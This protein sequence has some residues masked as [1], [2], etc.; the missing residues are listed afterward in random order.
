MQSPY[1][2]QRET[3]KQ[4][5]F[6]VGRYDD[7][8]GRTL[9]SRA[10]TSDEYM[11][12][13]QVTMQRHPHPHL[14]HPGMRPYM[15]TGVTSATPS[16]PTFLH[17]PQGVALHPHMLSVNS[18]S[19]HMQPP[20]VSSSASMLTASSHHGAPACQ[21]PPLLRV[22]PAEKVE[23][24]QQQ[25]SHQQLHKY[26]HPPTRG[27]MCASCSTYLSHERETGVSRLSPSRV[28]GHIPHHSPHPPYV[29]KAPP[30]TSSSISPRYMQMVG[31]GESR[32]AVRDVNK[33][34][35]PAHQQHPYSNSTSMYPV[36]QQY[37]CETGKVHPALQ[38][39]YGMQGNV[40]M[41]SY[42]EGK[43]A[44]NVRH[45][46]EMH[47]PKVQDRPEQHIIRALGHPIHDKSVCGMPVHSSGDALVRG[48]SSRYTHA[49]GDPVVGES[50]ALY[51]PDVSGKHLIAVHQSPRVETK[52]Q[53]SEG[54][55]LDLT[56]KREGSLNQLEDD[57]PLDLSKKLPSAPVHYQLERRQSAGA[58]QLS[59]SD[60]R[61]YVDPRASNRVV[62]MHTAGDRVKELSEDGKM[63]LGNQHLHNLETS[64][65]TYIQKCKQGVPPGTVPSSHNHQ[66]PHSAIP[67][68]P[69]HITSNTVAV[70]PSNSAMPLHS[71]S[72]P[73]QH[74]RSPHP[75]QHSHLQ[76]TPN[77]QL[78]GYGLNM[79]SSPHRSPFSGDSLL[80]P[81]GIRRPQLHPIPAPN[82]A[83]TL[84]TTNPSCRASPFQSRSCTNPFPL[85]VVSTSPHSQMSTDQQ[86][87]AP[88]GLPRVSP[89]TESCSPQS[90]SREG[91]GSGGGVANPSN[92]ESNHPSA[93]RSVSPPGSDRRNSWDDRRRGSVSKHEPIQNIIGNH[94]PA[95]ILY[96]ICRLCRQTYGSPYGFRKHFRNQHGFEPKA[97]HTI[98]QT[99]SAT[100]NARQL[101]SGSMSQDVD[102]HFEDSVQMY[103]PNALSAQSLNHSQYAVMP[104][105]HA[106]VGRGLPDDSPRS[107]SSGSPFDSHDS[108]QHSSNIMRGSSPHQKIRRAYSRSSI[109]NKTKTPVGA[110]SGS[111]DREDTKCLECPECGQTFQLN[112]FGSYKRHCRQHGQARGVG[113]SNTGGV[114]LY[115]CAECQ[116]TFPEPHLLQE[117]KIRHGTHSI[118]ASCHLCHLLFSSI[119]QVEEHLQTS[120]GQHATNKF[121]PCPPVIPSSLSSSSKLIAAD[122][123]SNLASSSASTVVCSPNSVTSTT[124]VSVSS[125][126]TSST[127][128]TYSSA[129]GFSQKV[130]TPPN[131]EVQRLP[132]D[133][134]V[135][136][137]SPDSSSDNK[138]I[139]ET[140][141]IS[142]S[143][144]FK[145]DRRKSEDESSNL[146]PKL[147]FTQDSPKG[148]NELEGKLHKSGD[149][150]KDSGY[151]E[152]CPS[153]ESRSFSTESSLAS[154][155]D[156]DDG[157]EFLYKH[158]KFGAHRKRGSSNDVPEPDAKHSRQEIVHCNTSVTG[159]VCSSSQPE[160][161]EYNSGSNLDSEAVSSVA[162]KQNKKLDIM[163]KSPKPVGALGSDKSGAFATKNLPNKTEA[164]HQ[165]P[166]VWDRVTRSQAGKNARS[167]D[168]S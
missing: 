82:L 58:R 140:V 34:D 43:A 13:M 10:M 4:D 15:G 22:G 97:E 152:R 37:V 49:P 3:V 124:S 38:A 127:R 153:N 29:S 72:H 106:D 130:T 105:S 162:E 52:P 135:T 76:A 137:A 64:L 32:L 114:G 62:G 53:P 156:A 155:M 81:V 93:S 56:L 132:A 164:R 117:H 51:P 21:P 71:S 128:L 73:H 79:N 116:S 168:V 100:K 142:S 129:T 161:R 125:D 96:L 77:Q 27:C 25:L 154:P 99:I 133:H 57:R 101:T 160:T 47:P 36:T 123:S 1:C 35:N 18:S 143:T 139:P 112:D 87:E 28:D 41:S 5:Q 119:A 90:V 19:I 14:P 134:I 103:P 54:P 12:S 136:S 17:G 9:G 89:T 2:D 146:S 85:S 144:Q 44:V 78:P 67:P 91:A 88:S 50:S 94:N 68:P 166:F 118:S 138:K 86:I 83:T 102:G 150:D 109:D 6:H 63:A 98:V 20:V 92:S 122:C 167:T 95:D 23:R 45:S 31:S 33:V 110:G 59:G 46:S 65:E 107:G 61:A 70:I 141:S 39:S 66:L 120:H 157:L 115:P 7:S 60:G 16:T 75:P 151:S 40:P 108:Q 145:A 24:H 74:S 113:A 163:R 69:H 42:V 11:H 111:E 48:S 26:P 165:M 149:D 121:S 159:S 84:G 147:T 126:K 80:S 30:T 55:V 158:K 8:G 148:K 104:T 131:M